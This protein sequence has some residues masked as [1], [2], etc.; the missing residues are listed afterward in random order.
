LKDK[1]G[2]IVA[3]NPNN[4][5]ILAMASSPCFDPNLFVGGIDRT[6]WKEIVSSKGFPLQNRALSGQ[7]PPGSIFKILV[8]L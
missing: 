8:A 7:Y 2:A 4:G 3:L 5:E 1:K 6:T